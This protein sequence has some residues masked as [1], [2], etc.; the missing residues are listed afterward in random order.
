ML[1]QFNKLKIMR[2]HHFNRFAVASLIALLAWSGPGAMAQTL[3][4]RYSF[5]DPTGSMTFADSVGGAAW[6]GSLIG[7]AYMDD[8]KLHLDGFG[9]FGLMPGAMISGESAVT[10]ELW[11]SFSNENPVW[12][13]VFAFGDQDG[14]GA[15][16]TGLDYTHFAGG[17]WQ[18]FDLSTPVGGVWVNNPGGLNGVENVHLTLIVDPVNNQMYYYNDTRIASNPGVNGNNGIVPPLNA[19]VDT[20]SLIGKSL[21]DIDATLTGSIDEFRVYSGVLSP[22]RVAIN[23]AAGP[24]NYVADV[25][26]LQAVHLSSPDPVLSVN[27]ISQQVFTGDFANVSGVNLVLYG[28]A[29]F[30]SGNEAVLMV[31]ASGAVT[32]MAPGTTTLVASFGGLS[33]TNT[34]SV[35][36]VPAVLKHR[37]SFAAN[38]NDSVGTA[39]GILHGS[40]TIS[41]GKAV[42][43]G[44][45]G[46]HIELPGPAINLP[47]YKAVTIE[48]WVDFGDV[49]SWSRLWD[50]GHDNATSEIYF[51]PRGPGNGG[52]HRISQNI[53]G[54]RT[55]DWQGVFSNQTAQVTVVMD[56]PTGRMSLYKNGKL[57]YARYDATA[58]LSL[59]SNTMAVIGRSLVAADQ[60]M[61]GSIDEF[62]IY[63][64][65]LTPEEIAMTYQ[66]G[67]N[68]IARDPGTLQ[69]IE[70]AQVVYPSSA[71]RMAPTILANF[72]NLA[73]HSLLQNN[74]AMVNGL[75]LTSSDTNVIMVLANNMIRTFGPGKATLTATYRGKTSTTQVLVGNKS[76]L[77]HRYSF[78]GNYNDS[79][80]AAHGMPQGNASVANG[81]LVLDGTDGTYLSLPGGL[82]KNFES[83]TIDTWVDLN[84]GANW[85]RLWYFGNDRV[86]EFYLGPF[87]NGGAHHRY[88]A[89]L[90][91][92]SGNMD[93]PPGWQ[94][95]TLHV[96]T[97]FGEGTMAIYTNGVS[98]S[99][100]NADGRPDQIGEWFTWI[101]RSPYAD[102]YM[103]SAVEEFRIYKGRLSP[104]EILA[105]HLLGPD[106]L[107]STAAPTLAAAVS[108][109][110]VTLRWPLAAAGFVVQAS[111][112][113]AQG[114]WTPLTTA[115]VVVGSEWQLTVPSNVGARYFRLWK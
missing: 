65:A 41:G 55:T 91:H 48:A 99:T 40:A 12:T 23:H 47:S 90:S 32:A 92:G 110:N 38:A 13:R 77:A 97:V 73:G 15:K 8:G 107:L 115:P 3:K 59:I 86:D 109:G 111:E 9:S 101:G 70:V 72:Q 54:G 6:N 31:N 14:A 29:T 11:G 113:L 19:V 96:T 93:I 88:S 71:L 112:S 85:A 44:V 63:S 56:P 61:P 94:N 45:Y 1:L 2:Q 7:F 75:T 28:G 114:S 67:P 108:G 64:G 39:H 58:P 106:T 52:R 27:Q 25:G 36:D 60:Y 16:V 26:V 17:N 74:S 33:A 81:K 69:S 68:S 34:L 87:I 42:L 105:S 37:Y 46:T 43:D 10:I 80:G 30:T 102:P 76:Q 50:F 20:F 18:N 57:V 100:I 49:P 4:H 103:N 82:L 78:N 22:Q 98:E 95:M 53:G 5:N 24:D 66:S 89:G 21:H 51:A 62:R 79:V 35:L 83:L 104:Q 84:A